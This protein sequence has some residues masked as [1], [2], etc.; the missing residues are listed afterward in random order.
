MFLYANL[1]LKHITP[2]SWSLHCIHFIND[3]YCGQFV[4]TI[5]DFITH[6]IFSGALGK[7]TQKKTVGKENNGRMTN[8]YNRLQLAKYKLFP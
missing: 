1:P 5:C 2:K 4:D 7:T 8:F 3:K 6:P